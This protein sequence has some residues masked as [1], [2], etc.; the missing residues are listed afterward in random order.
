MATI[1]DVAR[2]AG[3]SM[4]TVSKYMNG[5]TVR[6]E[7]IAPIRDAIA[8]LDYR[9]NPF[10]RGLKAQRN[11]SVGILL[12]DLSTPFF[13]SIIGA[14]AKT[15]REYGYHSIISC[16]DS[17]HGLERD[18]LRFLLH[19]GIDGLIY[20]PNDLTAEEYQEITGNGSI[21]VVQVDRVIQG[22]HSDTVLVDNAQASYNA[23]LSLI[24]KGHQRIALI[25]GPKSVLTAK[26][27]QVGYLKALSD[28]GI[29]YDDGL[30]ISGKNDF[31]TG[32]RGCEELLKLPT[33]P[34]AVFTTNYNI[35]LG[36]ITAARERG[37]QIPEQMDVFGFDCVDI[38]TMLKPPI[39]VVCQPEQEIG[40]TAAAY[41]IERMQGLTDKTR[42]TRLECYTASGKNV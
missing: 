30:F 26:E 19:N 9:V 16:Y 24:Q 41:L 15:F 1:K 4:S 34:T 11:R 6:P 40:H 21:P 5:G 28:N 12:P 37:I 13:G 36:F 29:H 32:Y 2:M 3:V 22:V 17:D 33:L 20:I 14:M 39:P 35:T 8:A 38:C 18:N 23:V 27:R 42:T 25:T 10:A 31:A 7:N